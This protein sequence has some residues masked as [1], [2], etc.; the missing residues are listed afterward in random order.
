MNHHRS[1]IPLAFDE[2]VS[3]P[4]PTL[5]AAGLRRVESDRFEHQRARQRDLI[6]NDIRCREA[7]LEIR[8]ALTRS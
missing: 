4:A 2:P 1:R 7:D 6:C 8:E 3:A 5:Q